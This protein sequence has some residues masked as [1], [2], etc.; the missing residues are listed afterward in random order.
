MTLDQ[1]PRHRHWTYP[2]GPTV[3]VMPWIM[4]PVP[5]ELR[6][7]FQQF[8]FRQ[9][10]NAGEYIFT[11]DRSID[12]LVLLEK[13]FSGRV[14]GS[15]YNQSTAAMALSIPY[16]LAGGNHNF[17][18]HRA[19]NGRYFALTDITVIYLDQDEMK[20]HTAQDEKLRFYLN[21]LL[22]L[23][24]QSDRIGFA[25]IALL[26]VLSR[27]LMYY[28]SWG[29]AYAERV[30]YQGDEWLRFE[31]LLS[32]ERIAQVTSASIVQIKRCIAELRKLNMLI[33]EEPY[34]YVRASTLDP[35]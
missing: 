7:I 2:Y 22:E 23:S 15:L 28:L 9:T 6:Q 12:A 35:Q 29:F 16:R 1:L 10:L 25:S 14:F 3:P 27:L 8:G 13:G 34:W 19:G 4:P 11:Q 21:V 31:T 5:D 17:W 24:F 26:P 33:R 32:Q 20:R 18:S 30:T